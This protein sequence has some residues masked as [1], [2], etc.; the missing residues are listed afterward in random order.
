VNCI[1][2]DTDILWNVTCSGGLVSLT[3]T[4]FRL[5]SQALLGDEHVYTALHSEKNSKTG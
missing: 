5:A 1:T 2:F 4:T 3:G